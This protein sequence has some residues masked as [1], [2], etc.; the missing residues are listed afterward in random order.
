MKMCNNYIN[1]QH[2]KQILKVLYF[3]CKMNSINMFNEG[4]I[5]S[6]ENFT[7]VTDWK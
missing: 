1:T 2:C 5:F 3:A 7:C 6:M 4:L